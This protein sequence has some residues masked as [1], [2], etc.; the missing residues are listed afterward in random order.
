MYMAVF[1]EIIVLIYI[2]YETFMRFRDKDK[3]G[4]IAG[5]ILNL[6]VIVCI[7]SCLNIF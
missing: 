6:F 2:V 3:H 7:F 5:I 4:F 1:I